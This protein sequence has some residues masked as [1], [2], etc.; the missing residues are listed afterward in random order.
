[1]GPPQDIVMGPPPLPPQLA[2]SA[3]QKSRES[4]DVAEKYRRLKRKYF[5][6]EEKHKDTLIQLQGSGERNVKWRSERG[7]LL[8]DRIAELETNPTINP[9]APIPDPPFTAFPRSL[10]STHGQKLFVTNLRNAIDE[11]ERED[12]DVDPLLLSRHIGPQARKRQEAELKEKLEEEARE[13]RRASRRPRAPQKGK[14]IGNPLTFAPAQPPPSSVPSP[15]ILVSSTGTRLRL[16]PPA[17]PPAD[18]A[19]LAP[20]SSSAH[21][22]PQHHLPQH[23]QRRRSDSP[24]S[25]ELSPQDEYMPSMTP[26]GAMSPS[27]QHAGPPPTQ[28][29]MQMTLRASSAVPSRP[30][31]LQRHAKPKRLKAHTVTTKSFSIPTVPRDKGAS[32]FCPLMSVS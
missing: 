29:Q 16:K 25:P 22:P 32:R 27:Y 17:P 19:T 30:S 14:D 31:D 11:I 5:D 6:L 12:P 21:N 2:Q 20:S 15:P 13:A 8:L 10:M 4:H 7:N 3:S 18:P 26:L 9:N 28:A 23:H 24:I 1:M